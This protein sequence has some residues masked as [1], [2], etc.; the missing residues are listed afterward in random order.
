M[1]ADGWTGLRCH[2]PE[3]SSIHRVWRPERARST[4]TDGVW[5]NIVSSISHFVCLLFGLCSYKQHFLLFNYLGPFQ[6]CLVWKPFSA[7][8]LNVNKGN[9]DFLFDNSD[10][11]LK[12]TRC[13]RAKFISCKITF[14]WNLIKINF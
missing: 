3:S 4:V 8:E 11:T 1:F 6:S 14:I 12:I 9:F 13:K 10:F 5:K 2:L 7:T